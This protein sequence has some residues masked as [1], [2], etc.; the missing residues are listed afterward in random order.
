MQSINQDKSARN[1]V[2]IVDTAAPHPSAIESAILA[3]QRLNA[4]LHALL[5]EDLDLARMAALPFSIEIDRTSGESRPLEPSKVDQTLKLR[6]QSARKLLEVFAD[7]HKVQVM[8]STVRGHYLSEALSASLKTDIVFLC[9]TRAMSSARHAVDNEA[10]GNGQPLWL[11]F[12]GSPGAKN[13]LK[14]AQ[15][16][17]GSDLRLIVPALDSKASEAMQNFLQEQLNGDLDSHHHFVLAEDN[18]GQQSLIDQISSQDVFV[19][20]RDCPIL[21]T[22]GGRELLNRISCQ[23]VLVS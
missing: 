4:S 21:T 2:L 23:V 11:Y 5:I 15:E 6:S 9:R 8:S 10:T 22:P 19:L 17:V 13:A 14:Y 12:D 7:R 3:A 20:S 1:I 18:R 16:V